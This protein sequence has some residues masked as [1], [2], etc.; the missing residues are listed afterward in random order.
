MAPGNYFAFDIMADVV[1]GLE[2]NLLGMTRWR[3]I[4]DSIESSNVRMGAILQA[5]ELKWARLDKWFFPTAIYGRNRFVRFVGGLL[6]VL[7]K[8]HDPKSNDLFSRLASAVDPI[9]G[10]GFKPEQIAAESTT[11][12]VAGKYPLLPPRLFLQKSD[13]S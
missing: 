8:G 5:P 10:T 2:Y 12:I 11:L 6:R 1:F 4:C 3:Y 7:A 9:T 13:T